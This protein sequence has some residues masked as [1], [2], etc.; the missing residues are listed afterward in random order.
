M[1]GNKIG[2]AALEMYIYLIWFYNCK[3]VSACVKVEKFAVAKFCPVAMEFFTWQGLL[4]LSMSD[5]LK[6]KLSTLW[7]FGF[8]KGEENSAWEVCQ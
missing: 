1:F 7:K 2:V 6:T 8:N 4:F 5:Y 3:G